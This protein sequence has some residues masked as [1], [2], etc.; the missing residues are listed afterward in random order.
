MSLCAVPVLW[1]DAVWS[2]MSW[3]LWI[4]LPDG[5]WVEVMFHPV[6]A[7]AICSM[8]TRSWGGQSSD[9]PIAAPYLE[10][11]LLMLLLLSC[12]ARL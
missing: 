10:L 6:G 4:T 8:H 3:R 12:G 9:L 5:P 1:G 11:L 2:L 7:V